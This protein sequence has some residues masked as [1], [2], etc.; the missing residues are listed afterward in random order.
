VT[1]RSAP[2]IVLSGPAQG[3]LALGPRRSPS[4]QATLHLESS[5]TSLP[6]LPLRW[7]PGGANQ[8]P[9]GSHSR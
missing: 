3:S 2:A 6:P 1:V 5:D 8:F 7:L 4:H 9:G